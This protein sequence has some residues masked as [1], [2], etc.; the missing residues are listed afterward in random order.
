MRVCSDMSVVSLVSVLR[1]WPFCVVIFVVYYYSRS[2][3]G[4][5]FK[6]Y[7]LIEEAVD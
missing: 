4:R 7:Y 5:N 6:N 1:F 3:D 2:V